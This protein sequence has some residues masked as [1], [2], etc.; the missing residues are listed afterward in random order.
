MNIAITPE[1]EEVIRQ[2]IETGQFDDAADVV[3]A[4]LEAL[5][6]RD[7]FDR[8]QAELRIGLEQFDRGEGVPF[9]RE[10]FE[11]IKSGAYENWKMGKPIK[12]ATSPPIIL[13]IATT[14][15]SS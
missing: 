11:Q 15:Y 8:L 9:T 2:R 10:R 1:D 13:T 4:A 12:D 7:R 3:H 6:E 5:D 14:N